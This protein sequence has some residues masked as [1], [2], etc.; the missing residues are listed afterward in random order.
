M[1]S[2]DENCKKSSEKQITHKTYTK[3]RK[4]ERKNTKHHDGEQNWK[5]SVKLGY[6]F[7][8]ISTMDG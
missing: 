8:I 7:Q 1:K 5:E 6:S 4:K 2:N 3:R